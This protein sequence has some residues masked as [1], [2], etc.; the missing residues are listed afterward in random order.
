MYE[1]SDY[2]PWIPRKHLIKTLKSAPTPNQT[3]QTSYNSSK[4][5]PDGLRVS[6]NE[7]LKVRGCRA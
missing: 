6:W 7:V 3:S 2:V 4:R 1:P 5:T